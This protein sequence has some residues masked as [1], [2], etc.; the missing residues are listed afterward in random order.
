MS[1]FLSELNSRVI[2]MVESVSRGVVTISTIRLRY[3]AFFDVVPVKGIGSGFL[4]DGNHIITSAHVIL[5][6]RRVDVIFFNGFRSVGRVIAAD[7]YRDLALVHVENAAEEAH[8]ISLGDSDLL[9]VGELVF[10]IGSPLGLPGPTI[11]MGVISATGRSIIGRNVFLED[12]I[13]TDAAVNPGN[14][15]GPLVN[16][17]GE[18]VGVVT[19]LIPFAQ[20]VGFAIPINNVKR[21]IEMIKLYGRPVRA[22]IGIYTVAI[23]PQLASAYQLPLMKGLLVV[24]VIADTPAHHSGIK[25]GDIITRV[26]GREVTRLS[27]L[28]RLIE[29]SIEK[30]F[31]ELEVYREHYGTRILR[32]PIIIEEIGS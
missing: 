29:D 13:Q 9:R 28:R 16:V 24:K 8:P 27:Q 32:V 23:N 7:P 20:G 19:A 22:M 17:N 30:G 10:A 15:G 1:D 31:V 26:N 25:P 2:E 6:A 4:L 14:S 18:A 21:L 12:L 5:D 11:T 3:D